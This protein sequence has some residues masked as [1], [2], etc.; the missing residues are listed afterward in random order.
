MTVS[1]RAV[2]SFHGKQGGQTDILKAWVFVREVS[3][4]S[5]RNFIFL[6]PTHV[7]APSPNRRCCRAWQRTKKPRNKTWTTN[8]VCNKLRMNV[9]KRIT[10]ARLLDN[11]FLFLLVFQ[12]IQKDSVTNL[13][14]QVALL[15]QKEKPPSHYSVTASPLLV[16]C[17]HC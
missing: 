11:M 6:L 7:R 9:F 3:R 16:F 2:R 14:S 12:Q 13:F 5:W 15:F 8:L 1:D 4:L 10:L 17:S